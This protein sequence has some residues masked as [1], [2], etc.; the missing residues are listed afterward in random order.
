MATGIM[1]WIRE[2]RNL[3]GC[4]LVASKAAWDKYGATKTPEEAWAEYG[5]KSPRST[6]QLEGE[7]ERL[8]EIN[9]ELL[10]A[11]K[12]AR[13]ELMQYVDLASESPSYAMLEN[14]MHKAEREGVRS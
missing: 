7:V 9:A 6:T 10:E 11:C 5:G 14:A 4:G 8:K 1:D 13:D 2:F 3:A 12:A